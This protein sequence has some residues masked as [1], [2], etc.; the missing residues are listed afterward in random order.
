MW[1]VRRIRLALQ[2]RIYIDEIHSADLLIFSGRGDYRQAY[3]FIDQLHKRMPSVDLPYYV[4]Q[5]L[6]D[7]I[8]RELGIPIYSAHEVSDNAQLMTSLLRLSFSFSLSL[9]LYFFLS[10]ITLFYI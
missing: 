2:N 8:Q 6:L 3:G 10:S 9:S 4:S 1:Q 5:E 7:T